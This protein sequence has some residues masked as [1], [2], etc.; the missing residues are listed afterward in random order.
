MLACL[1][2]HFTN[3]PLFLYTPFAA[4]RS[5]QT[6]HLRA[7]H[8]AEG[9]S[10]S[11][12]STSGNDHDLEDEIMISVSPERQAHRSQKRACINSC[13]QNASKTTSQCR[14]QCT[15]NGRSTGPGLYHT[16]APSPAPPRRDHIYCIRGCATQDQ[17][18][19]DACPPPS[20]A[21]TFE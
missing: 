6:P 10:S 7:A 20:F 8:Y 9:G 3:Y 21:M 15:G 5:Y 12:T 17:E 18:C 11:S 13:T 1:S 2:P 14:T 16:T 4:C 19:R